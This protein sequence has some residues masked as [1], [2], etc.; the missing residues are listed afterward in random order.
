M[1]EPTLDALT[2]RLDRL[3]RENRRLKVVGVLALLGLVSVAL[4]G[5]AVLSDAPIVEAQTFYV[6]DR[7]GKVRATLGADGLSIMDASGAARVVVSGTSDPPGL[8]LR[9]KAGAVVWKAP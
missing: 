6:R 4:M 7:V 9:D 5:Q 8:N 2:R 1:A 3:E